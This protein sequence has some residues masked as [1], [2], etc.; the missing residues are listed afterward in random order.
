MK[1]ALSLFLSVLL[2]VSAL[3]LPAAAAD[4]ALPGGSYE[5]KT[6]IIY[7]GNVRGD[8][9]VYPRIKAARDAYEAA[10]ASVYVVDT[11]N[12]LQGSAAANTDRG[13]GIT[14]L[15]SAVG[16]EFTAMGLA[17]FGYTDATTGYPYH[18]N[19]TRYYTQAQLCNGVKEQTY[20][21]NRD[22]S[23]TAVLP[24]RSTA[25]FHAVASNVIAR[26]DIYAKG[27]SVTSS[28]RGGLTLG[29]Y[30]LTDP[31]VEQNVQDADENGVP[32]VSVLQPRPAE[33]TD[34]GDMPPAQLIICLSN[35][36]VSG[37][38]YG[39]IV[40]DAPTAGGM[41]MGA[42]VID[43][44]T[45]AITHE[46]LALSDADETVAAL[47]D[48]VQ[49]A[50]GEVLF[51]SEVVLNGSDD[52]NWNGESNLGDLTADALVWYAENFIDGIDESLPLVAIQNGGNCDQ[53]IYTGDVTEI[54][55]LHA[56]PFSPMGI[57]VLTVTGEQLLET[58]EA[59]SQRPD[60]PGFAQV[61]GLT[62]T[63]DLGQDYDGGAAYGD[64][65]VA[66]SVNR[67]T[68][69]S[70]NGQPFDPAARYAL[71]CDNFLMNGSDTYYTLQNIR[72]A[73][74][75]DYINNGTGVRVRDAVAMY[76]QQ[77]LGGVI[78]EEYAEPQ[79]RI[80]VLF[81]SF[82]DV[83]DGAWYHDAVGWAASRGITT[84][85]TETA[86][87][88]GEPCTR[89]H[90]L[91]FLWRASGQPDSTLE[92]PFADLSGSEYYYD[93]ALWAAEQGLVEGDVFDAAAP[94]LRSDVVTYLWQLSGSI[95]PE[96]ENPFEDVSADAPYA[97]AVLW[98]VDSGI[99]T[100]VSE[101]A[102]D[103]DAPCTRGEIVTFLYRHFAL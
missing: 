75:G 91:T 79:G 4:P 19:F 96:G 82:D 60:C 80:T 25:S 93:A 81:P 20:A 83:A 37:S 50:A 1:K 66:D 7:T 65:Y 88:P 26:T 29:F 59:A 16:Y 84:G 40:I 14:D 61:S 31:A 92:N 11:G 64:Y 70:V 43:N 87:E 41:V 5:G 77:E 34:W 76:V 38:E 24:A 90:I 33:F 68:I 54:D 32:Y 3:A 6:V 23:V 94:C 52:L 18:G 78:G 67:V 44:E 95:V 28:R 13:A 73:G 85:A 51:T 103:P 100:G 72:D 74:E 10:G 39:D 46:E 47:A 58:L 99:T 21:Q 56:L 2:L 48:Q 15:M 49:S 55:L 71:V 97:H 89:A 98:A 86:F 63:I 42:Y 35:A 22:G 30:G 53:F 102:F 27:I 69:T 12:Y 17:E 9:S 57:G 8:V 45:L 62:Y 101:T 36:G